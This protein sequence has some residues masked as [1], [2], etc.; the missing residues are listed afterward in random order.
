MIQ[1]APAILFCIMLLFVT[2]EISPLTVPE[3]SSWHIL[4]CSFYPL[5]SS[6]GI[7][8]SHHLHIKWTISSPFPCLVMSHL[9]FLKE[10]SLLGPNIPFPPEECEI[11]EARLHQKMAL[12]FPVTTLRLLVFFSDRLS[13][14]WIIPWS[15]MEDG[16]RWLV[17]SCWLY[18]GRSY[19]DLW[20]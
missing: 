16:A 11:M 3:K 12:F 4:S 18:R 14:Q 8:T 10:P 2:A 15:K 20:C 7:S 9:P 17:H 13:G 6:R 5:Y 19:F 1:K